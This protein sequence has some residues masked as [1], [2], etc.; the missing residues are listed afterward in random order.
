MEAEATAMRMKERTQMPWSKHKLMRVVVLLSLLVGSLV[1]CSIFS[2]SQ[3]TFS[4]A[5]QA[6]DA[7]C[8]AL[9]NDDAQTLYVLQL[10]P[11]QHPLSYFENALALAHEWYDLNSG[12]EACL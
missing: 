8:H 1:S 3:K 5:Q 10:D 7:Y 2:T 6:L 11:P 9:K 4:T 12:R